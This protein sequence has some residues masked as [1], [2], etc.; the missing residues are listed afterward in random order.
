MN[1]ISSGKLTN[2][3]KK[4][5][6]IDELMKLNIRNLNIYTVPIFQNKLISIGRNVCRSVLQPFI[7]SRLSPTLLHTA[8]QLTLENGI[9]VIIEYGQY[10]TE[11]SEMKNSN[12]FSS[13][14]DSSGS[15]QNY[16]IEK[17][18]FIFYYINKDGVRLT[19][20]EQEM[21]KDFINYVKNGFSDSYIIKLSL[22]QANNLH[23]FILV[24][25]AC[26]YFKI[27]VREYYR[28]NFLNLS[29]DFKFVECEIKNKINLEKL[30]AYCKREKW[31][32]NN[33][34]FLWN[35]CQDFAAE[36]IKITKAIRINNR[37][38][39]RM[40]EKKLLPGCIIT[41]LWKN[42]KLSAINTIGRIPVVGFL[43]DLLI[44]PNLI[45]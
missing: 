43:F 27:P 44:C 26:N 5:L 2:E 11:D 39:I 22:L 38:K 8:I 6:K 4:E 19:I 12:I 9:I 3:G 20:I 30:I 34:N 1:F 10:Y 41:Q 31:E 18:D 23:N 15:S 45:E 16:R 37:D 29:L 17:N 42:E 28:L 32:A 25:I 7:H 40:Y 33:Y 24:I 21:L 13:C 36:I 35:N 14:S